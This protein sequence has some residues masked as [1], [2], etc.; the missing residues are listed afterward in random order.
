[1]TIAG[2]D[3]GHGSLVRTLGHVLGDGQHKKE[4]TSLLFDQ[5]F[6]LES[7]DVAGGSSQA[8]ILRFMVTLTLFGRALSSAPSV[9]V[10]LSTEKISLLPGDE[11][12]GW[13]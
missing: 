1:M 2:R 5:D 9:G 4:L 8:R 13:S 12:S 3:D 6:G 10:T 7:F 11:P